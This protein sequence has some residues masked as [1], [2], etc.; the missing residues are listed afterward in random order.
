MYIHF[1]HLCHNFT[2][3]STASAVHVSN[4]CKQPFTLVLFLQGR[5]L[6]LVQFDQN[7]A[8]FSVAVCT[9]TARADTEW[10]VV[11][12]TAKDMTLSPRTCNGG[13][14][15]LFKLGPDGSKLEHVHTV[16]RIIIQFFCLKVNRFLKYM[17][18]YVDA[19]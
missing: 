7:V 3:I 5:T 17:Y 4:V 1:C 9:F 10:Y 8:A 16:L 19:T 6:D 15:V 2:C 12:G 18:I 13:A 11:V 14:L